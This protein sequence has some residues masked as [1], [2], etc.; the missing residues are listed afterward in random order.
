MTEPSFVNAMRFLLS[1][2][3]SLFAT[4]YVSQQNSVIN[5]ELQVIVNC[6]S[7]TRA[8][9]YIMDRKHLVERE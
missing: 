3:D 4:G 1:I 9:G 2:N 8:N 7:V 6:F 5:K